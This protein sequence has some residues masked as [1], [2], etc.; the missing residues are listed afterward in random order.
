[1]AHANFSPNWEPPAKILRSPAKAKAPTQWWEP[2]RFMDWH[3]GGGKDNKSKN[4]ST[5][6]AENTSQNEQKL[7]AFVA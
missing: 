3:T 5:A 7:S 2:Q 1:M 6:K 4:H